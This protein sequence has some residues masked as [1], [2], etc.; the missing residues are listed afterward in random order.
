MRA[1][2]V[3]AA[4]VPVLRASVVPTL[5]FCRASPCWSSHG[6]VSSR[7]TFADD[8]PL[9]ET[10]AHARTL[11]QDCHTD[12][13]LA[14]DV[15]H[16]VITHHCDQL[17]PPALTTP[18]PSRWAGASSSQI[19]AMSTSNHKLLGHNA[20]PTHPPRPVS[21]FLG[22]GGRLQV[23]SLRAMCPA[24]TSAPRIAFS[25]ASLMF[26]LGNDSAGGAFHGW[27]TAI[28]SKTVSSS[29]QL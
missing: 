26:S 11:S 6:L 28:S 8:A 23:V 13:S 1:Q 3:R 5:R 22:E 29:S 14:R 2:L 16:S 7:R 25:L 27:F 17:I 4:E 20:S 10:I 18:V 19:L 12:G 15:S 9:F 24:Y 21:P